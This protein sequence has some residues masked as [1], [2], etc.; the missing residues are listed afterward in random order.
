[1]ILATNHLNQLTHEMASSIEQQAV[2]TKEVVSA[3]DGLLGGSC[4]ISSSSAELASSA[5]Q[6]SKMSQYLL[7]LME[8]FHL[9]ERRELAVSA[10][11]AL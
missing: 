7:Q 5:E 10:R 11:R 2:A 4:E 8:R 9:H 1:M 3:M 6:M